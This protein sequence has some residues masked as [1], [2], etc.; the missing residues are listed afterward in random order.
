MNGIGIKVN[1]MLCLGIINY[2]LVKMITL[3]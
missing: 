3:S 1:I 2:L